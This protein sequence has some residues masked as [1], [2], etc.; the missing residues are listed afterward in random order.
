VKSAVETLSPTRVK[1]TVEV[2]F[3]ELKP[4]LDSAY[5]RISAQVNIPGF[6]KGKV[7]ARIIDQRIGRSVVL[8]E[9][10]NDAVGA[11]LDA[12]VRE[13]EVKLLGRPEVEVGEI[14]DNE[15]LEFTA[16]ADVVPEFDLPDYDGIEVTV[17]AAE[18]LDE[19]VD[20]QLEALRSRFGTLLPVERSSD[21]GDV[22]LFDMTGQCEGAVVDDLVATSLSYELGSDGMV[23]GFD[24][25]V[26]GAAAGDER[27]F[28]FVPE[29]GEYAGRTIEVTVSVSAVRERKL[30]EIDDDFAAL[31]SE[32]DTVEELRADLRARVGRV[33][34]LEQ[35]YTAR[36]KV[37]EA[38]LASVDVPMPEGVI[39]AQVDQHFQDG[40]GDD[41]HRS[42]VA[43]QVRDSLKS[44]LVFDKIADA[45]KLT[46]SE[47][48]LSSWLVAQAPRYGLDP[49]EFAQQL[50]QAGQVSSAVAEV[51]RSKALAHVL[52]HAKVVDTHGDVVDLSTAD[53]S[54]LVA[55]GDHEDD[56]HDHEGH[57]HEGHEH[58]DSGHED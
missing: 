46:V 20:K 27:R 40:H 54:A 30:P 43:T 18:V 53:R 13:H 8:E 19:D 56:A 42:E 12:A 31:A 50:V 36:D 24:E 1:L 4:A 41:E 49:D 52:E 37:A 47:S 9:A 23:P 38:L 35:A 28:E 39:A 32:F 26:T 55:A 22:L 15:P 45:E 14:K 17:E 44:Q 57:D 5:K 11:N 33:K 6:R 16:E 10:V 25:A 7:P 2:P 29:G 21:Q 48:E 51:R 34:A 58:H 3:E